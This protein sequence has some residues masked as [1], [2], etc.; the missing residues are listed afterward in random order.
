MMSFMY[1]D[2]TKYDLIQDSSTQVCWFAMSESGVISS[3]VSLFSFR[4]V[5][6]M[7]IDKHISEQLCS[8]NYSV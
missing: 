5:H 6:M 1:E 4:P 3:Q 2:F 7:S 8:E